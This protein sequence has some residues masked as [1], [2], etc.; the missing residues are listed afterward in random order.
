MTDAVNQCATLDYSGQQFAFYI[1]QIA[2]NTY[3][4][5]YNADTAYGSPAAPCDATNYAQYNNADLF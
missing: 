3:T 1:S 5:L 4:C 2:A